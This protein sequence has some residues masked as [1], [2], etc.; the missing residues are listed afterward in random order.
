MQQNIG[1]FKQHNIKIHYSLMDGYFIEKVTFI[2]S[3]LMSFIYNS[4][5]FYGQTD[6]ESALIL[7][8]TWILE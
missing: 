6:T 7:V 1:N 8:K 2:K 5:F 4:Q 3:L